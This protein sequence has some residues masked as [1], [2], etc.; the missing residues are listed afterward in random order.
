MTSLPVPLRYEIRRS[1]E[2]GYADHGWLQSYHSFSFAQYDD[3]RHRQFGAL[4]VINEDWIA[5]GH[6][7]DTHGH[8][9]MEIITYVLEGE[10]SHKDSMGN[11]SMIRPG[12]VQ[13]MSAGSGV[14]HSEYNHTE[15]HTTHLLQI[16]LLPNQRNVKPG[17]EQK[18]F[19]E[20]EKRGR[21]RLVVSPDGRAGSVSIYQD[22][23][24]YAGLFD[25]DEMAEHY[26]PAGRWAYVH[27]ARGNVRVN[28]ISLQNGDALK[29]N[30][31]T[32]L[33][34]S[35]GSHAEVLLFDLAAASCF[36]ASAS[37]L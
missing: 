32:V 4:R 37:S 35:H 10:L 15:N 16:W 3:P 12:E 13:R 29:V 22:A 31:E 25:D 18:A 1:A 33:R 27:V 26:L 20:S 21:L 5:A 11:T 19:S 6:G 2:R 28:D 30:D 7:F 23:L 17:Y 24:V 14:M 34:L 9:D 36:S 8:R